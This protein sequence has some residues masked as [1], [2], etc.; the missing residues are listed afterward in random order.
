MNYNIISIRENPNY[1]E[2]GVDYF[3]AKWRI[4]RRIYFDCISN[5]ITTDSPLPRWYLLMKQNEIIGCYGL[6][7]NDFISRQD[8]YP[9]LCALFIEDKERGNEY[10]KGLLLHGRHEA[11]LL[12]YEKVY[13]ATA[14]IGYYEKY[15]WHY[16]ATGFHPWG[17][18]SR[19][20]ESN[21]IDKA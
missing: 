14:H 17:A 12:G 6:I 8:L 7:T 19:I 3:T 9:W 4:D 18:E 1:L 10:G 15:S 16:I 2:R 20:Y 13:L 5:S 11:A 21:T